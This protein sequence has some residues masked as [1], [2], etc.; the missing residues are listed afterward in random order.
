[1]V[2]ALVWNDAKSF[3]QHLEHMK[4]FRQSH[5]SNEGRL[6]PLKE[7]PTLYNI[8]PPSK[9]GEVRGSISIRGKSAIV[10]IWEIEPP[11]NS[12]N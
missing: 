9:T 7:M 6:A 11:R 10:P 5:H 4:K 12:Q 1:M 2:M 8:R 3:K